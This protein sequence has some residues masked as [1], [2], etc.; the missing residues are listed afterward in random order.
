MSILDLRSLRKDTVLL[1][2]ELA[3]RR[4]F[5]QRSGEFNNTM[6]LLIQAMVLWCDVKN[7]KDFYYR[8]FAR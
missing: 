4:D 3:L 7:A 2:V 5:S 1:I 6:N 8:I